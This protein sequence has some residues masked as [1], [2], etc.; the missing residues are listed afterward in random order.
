MSVI[1]E[2]EEPVR[3]VEYVG[4]VKTKEIHHLMNSLYACQIWQMKEDDKVLFYTLEEAKKALEED[5]YNGCRH[6]LSEYHK[7]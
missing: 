7:D 4:N 1:G 6:C 5:G 2:E 3:K